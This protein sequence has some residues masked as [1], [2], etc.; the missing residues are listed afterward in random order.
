MKLLAIFMA[1]IFLLACAPDNHQQGASTANESSD[2]KQPTLFKP[3][4]VLPYVVDVAA[5]MAQLSAA[6]EPEAV[7]AAANKVADWQI[8]HADD[9]ANSEL[10]NFQGFE[11]HSFG[12]WLMGAMAI[13]M[14][15]WGLIDGNE[16]YL[17]FIRNSA[18]EFA[19]GLE[20]RIF[21]A[22]DYVIGQAYLELYQVDQNPEYLG[23]L[24]ERLNYLYDNWPTV[25][26]H[27]FGEGCV[28]MEVE[29]RE[30]WTWVDALFMG[31]P[32]WIHLGQITGDERYTEY[33]DHEYW[34]SFDTFWDEDDSLLYRDRRYIP[35]RDKLG[36]KVFWG[37]GNGWV[38]ASFGRILPVLPQDHPSRDK[39]IEKFRAMSASLAKLQQ[40]D[41]SWPSSLTSPKL[42]PGPENS[43][44][45]FFAY[46]MAWGI[47]Q[48]ILDRDTYLPV[49]EK[50]WQSL[51]HSIYADG[52]L[53]YVQPSGSA[54]QTVHKES[55]DN[56]GVGA[57]LL[58]ASEI[59]RLAQQ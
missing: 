23:P 57:F 6:L 36:E 49:V 52:R 4:K 53:A 2:G 1:S 26:N 44:S 18:R 25:N 54:P 35:M 9:Y 55:T 40:A 48:G 10:K 3:P 31:A 11:R 34:A 24:K 29:C 13:G 7:R 21:D 43:G 59:Y 46:G 32:V 5:P 20:S 16:Q 38:Y 8:R 19:W 28:T 27:S 42:F 30:R 50:A 47:N 56:Y 22:D 33:G 39:Y 15:R 12:G 41:G 51:T 17:E 58:A 37:R 14:T 45:S